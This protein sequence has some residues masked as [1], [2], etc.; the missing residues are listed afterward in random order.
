MQKALRHLRT[1]IFIS[2]ISYFVPTSQKYFLKIFIF[3]YEQFISSILSI[4][5]QDIKILLYRD[6]NM[7]RTH[8]A[9][10]KKQ[11]MDNVIVMK[12]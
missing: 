3:I 7:Q 2:F 1:K 12:Y 8:L 4:L 5:N 9:F 10:F 11:V 6:T